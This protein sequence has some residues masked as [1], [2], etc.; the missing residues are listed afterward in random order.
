MNVGVLG[1]TFDPIH[2]GHISV[3]EECQIQLSLTGVIFVPAGR[4]W[5]KGDKPVLAA[6]HRVQMVELVIATHPGFILSTIEVERDG[7]SYTMETIAELQKQQ[8][9]EDEL[10]FIIGWDTLAQLPQWKQPSRLIEMCHLVAVPRPGYTLPELDS[11][12]AVIPGLTRRL[13]ILQRPEVDISATDIRD[14]VARGLSIDHLVP[15]PVAD[16]I[17]QHRLYVNR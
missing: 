11:L 17:R 10:F 16:Y 7:P 3:A 15:E 1:G 12:E 4:P 6:E 5:L 8:N 13:I 9:Q 2:N 14:R